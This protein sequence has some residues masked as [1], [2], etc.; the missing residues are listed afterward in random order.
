MVCAGALAA[1]QSYS[2]P[3]PDVSPQ[4]TPQVS[5]QPSP[6]ASLTP[7]LAAMLE[8]EPKPD[9][10]QPR[11]KPAEV[12]A[13]GAVAL[14]T[15]P[16]SQAS[17]S[18][19]GDVVCSGGDGGHSSGGDGGHS[20]GDGG[21]SGDDGGHSGGDG[22]H[23]GGDG[24]HSGGDGGHSGGDGG[25]SGGDGG[26]SGG[27]GGHSSGD[28]GHSGGDGGHS[29]GDGGHSGGDHRCSAEDSD[30][31]C[32]SGSID[33][34]TSSGIVE[35][36]LVSSVDGGTGG[37]GT[38]GGGT[39]NGSNGGSHVDQGAA[40]ENAPIA[41]D[42]LGHSAGAGS[43][44]GGDHNGIAGEP[45]DCTA[46]GSGGAPAETGAGNTVTLTGHKLMT[47]EVSCLDF[48]SQLP[49]SA[50]T[51]VQ[52]TVGHEQRGRGAGSRMQAADQ[53]VF[54]GVNPSAKEE[55]DAFLADLKCERALHPKL[56]LL[57]AFQP[58]GL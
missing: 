25:H 16:A 27:D 54:R 11:N 41:L 30:G 12:E 44:A 29:S 42:D 39:G 4:S 14:Q 40:A 36:H 2:Q 24:G 17:G 15:T 3:A 32:S 9:S 45:G 55:A 52:R 6:Q 21:H 22:G 51:Q 57:S 38:G 7:D 19:G 49:T 43:P 31:H 20:S 18:F 10:L 58:V 26:H 13:A 37:G 8:Q 56:H 5:R 46:G 23:S 33:D 1:V 48:N 35:S 53:D 50:A 34:G 47:G 28:G